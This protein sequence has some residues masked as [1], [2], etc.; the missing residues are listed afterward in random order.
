MATAT[1]SAA[2]IRNYVFNK[3]MTKEQHDYTDFDCN[4]YCDISKLINTAGVLGKRHYFLSETVYMTRKCYTGTALMV[5]LINN[6]YCSN[7]KCTCG[8]EKLY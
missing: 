2:K 8:S 7:T 3:I 4:L 1:Y 5:S 6:S